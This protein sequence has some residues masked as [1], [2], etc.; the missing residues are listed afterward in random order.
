MSTTFNHDAWIKRL[1]ESALAASESASRKA[2]RSGAYST[3]PDG[4]VPGAV[5]P[6]ASRPAPRN[7]WG[8]Q[9]LNGLLF[10]QTTVN[11][12]GDTVRL[13]PLGGSAHL[14]FDFIELGPGHAR[15]PQR[16]S[17]M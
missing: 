5:V 6:V 14:N 4:F 3:L 16:P 7:W 10:L 13:I 1:Q 11:V 17:P 2:Q 12:G 15:L 9:K 8:Q